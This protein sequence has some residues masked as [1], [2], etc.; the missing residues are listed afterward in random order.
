MTGHSYPVSWVPISI[1]WLLEPSRE[2]VNIRAESGATSGYVFG[3]KNLSAGPLE[4]CPDC[5]DNSTVVGHSER[6]SIPFPRI[7]EGTDAP[8]RINKGA[9]FISKNVFALNTTRSASRASLRLL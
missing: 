6:P 5:R 9:L 3:R 2:V 7:A 4:E 8:Y 1:R